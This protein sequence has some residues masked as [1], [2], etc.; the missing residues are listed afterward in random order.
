MVQRYELVK[1]GYELVKMRY[2]LVGNELTCTQSL[3]PVVCRRVHV[4]F[5]FVAYS[6]VQHISIVYMSNMAGVL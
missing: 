1:I 6:G 2:E 4:L 5:V 3:H